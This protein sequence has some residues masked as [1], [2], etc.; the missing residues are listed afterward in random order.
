VS[1]SP[2]V[3]HEWSV[4]ITVAQVEHQP[5]IDDE[6][7][8]LLLA[9]LGGPVPPGG[10]RA[11]QG[12]SRVPPGG[13]SESWVQYPP[14]SGRGHGFETRWWQHGE[15]AA[16]V[17]IE[18]TERYLAAVAEIGLDVRIVLIHIA[19]AAERL[20]E[21]VIGLERRTREQ[22][23]AW[24]VMLRA[25][26]APGSERRFPRAM[27]EGL[28]GLLPGSERSGFGRDGLVEV[29][30]WVDAV[31]AVD[32]TDRGAAALRAAMAELGRPD[33]TIVRAHATSAGEA[34]RTAYL[35]V[36]RRVLGGDPA[37]LAVSIRL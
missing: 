20:T 19:S 1:G 11:P 31:D 30:M 28:L 21:A 37:S 26:A 33:W 18:A 16:S 23:A 14:A 32:A 25:V 13:S 27:L 29:R 5:A 15:D 17:G 10:S 24:N 35:G 22:D 6:R 34:R 9:R 4:L 36:E 8:R 7:S 2:R 12:G 3:D